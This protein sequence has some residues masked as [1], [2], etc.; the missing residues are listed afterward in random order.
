LGVIYKVG[1]GNQNNQRQLAG[2]GLSN[3]GGSLSFHIGKSR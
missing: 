2:I 1:V 3:I